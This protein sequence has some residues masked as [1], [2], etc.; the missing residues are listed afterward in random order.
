MNRTRRSQ[1]P[2]GT[3]DVAVDPPG[4][5]APRPRRVSRSVQTC[6][7]HPDLHFLT[8]QPSERHVLKNG[9]PQ[10][11]GCGD[12]LCGSILRVRFLKCGDGS[13]RV[14]RF[15]QVFSHRGTKPRRSDHGASWLNNEKS[16]GSIRATG[17]LRR[18]AGRSS[19]RLVK[20]SQFS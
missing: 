20:R 10:R 19:V 14:R 8:L 2:Q 16:P 13:A 12:T 17:A 6:V 9:L 18:V 15:G 4:S 1:V 3:E 5:S 11:A 7:R